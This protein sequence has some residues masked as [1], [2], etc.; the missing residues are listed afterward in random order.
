MKKV[1]A[2][3][4]ILVL[5]SS[6][7]MAETSVAMLNGYIQELDDNFLFDWTKSVAYLSEGK[8]IVFFESTLSYGNL[9]LIGGE[10]I[11]SFIQTMWACLNILHVAASNWSTDI[12]LCL[13]I[14]HENVV[15]YWA[16]GETIIDFDGVAHPFVHY[17]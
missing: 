8:M 10:T 7:A 1:L 17:Q 13:F 4:A 16:D 12:P 15:L 14:V 11:R 3:L 5:I 9:E 2:I 6:A